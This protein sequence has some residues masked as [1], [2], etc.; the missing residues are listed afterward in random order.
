VT[1]A[2]QAVIAGAKVTLSNVN[3]GITVS[4][5]SSHAG[6]YRFDFVERYNH[7]LIL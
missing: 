7:S 2:S 4:K 6:T 1:D 5:E 3:R